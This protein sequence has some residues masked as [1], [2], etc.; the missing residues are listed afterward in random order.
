[1]LLVK[2]IV[3]W[4]FFRPLRF[5]TPVIIF[6][7]ALAAIPQGYYSLY[8][9][10]FKLTPSATLNQA[11]DLSTNFPRSPSVQKTDPV[12]QSLVV[13]T[14]PLI[15]ESDLG[16]YL[17]YSIAQKRVLH[18]LDGEHAILVL[19]QPPFFNV[20]NGVGYCSMKASIMSGARTLVFQNNFEGV[21]SSTTINDARYLQTQ[22]C[23]HAIDN[24]L[25][26]LDP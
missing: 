7:A 12:V 3:N 10:N 4:I 20:R 25:K 24:M 6:A 18:T 15:Q 19:A 11:E 9:H 8:D 13:D 22:A 16:S 1:M 5:L 21:S 17:R 14:V 23:H 2:R 26:E